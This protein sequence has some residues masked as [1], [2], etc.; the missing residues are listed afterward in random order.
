MTIMGIV[1]PQVGVIVINAIRVRIYNTN[2][3]ILTQ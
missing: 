2:K 1:L 3:H